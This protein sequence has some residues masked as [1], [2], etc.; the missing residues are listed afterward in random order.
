MQTKDVGGVMAKKEKFPVT[1]AIRALRKGK[2][3]FE[4][5]VYDYVDH[6]GTA[7]VAEV[8]GVSEHA[9]IKTLVLEDEGA[10][11]LIVLMHGDMEVGVGLLA[12][13]IG[14]KKAKPVLPE[15]AEKLT[16]YKTGGISPFGTRSRIPV[17]VEATILDLP[18]FYI[19]GG[20]RG[21]M[22]KITPD[23]LSLLSPIP[24]HVGVKAG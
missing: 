7:R 6:G 21:F 12:K 16:G 2:A 8:C 15:R 18:S 4:P 3:V 10:Q 24:V 23:V 1:P 11:P 9:V 5:E 19:N 14:R 13:T 17:Y 22:V 20:K